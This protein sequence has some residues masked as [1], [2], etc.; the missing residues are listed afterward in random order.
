MFKKQRPRTPKGKATRERALEA[1]LALFR[2]RGFDGTTMRDIARAAGLSLGAAYHYFPSKDALV[3]AYYE[4]IQ[5][6][7]E[8][9][10]AAACPEGAEVATRLHVLLETKLD[11]LARDRKILAALFRNVGDPAH[12][13]SVFSRQTSAIR[14]RSIAQFEEAFAGVALPGD[15]RRL[16]G[17]VTWLLHLGLVLF[18][19]HDRSRGQSRTRRLAAVMVE[20]IT[21]ILP[22][23]G[24]P[25]AEAAREKLLTIL[26]EL[27]LAGRGKP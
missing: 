11:L 9:R 22:Y 13:L 16:A 14:R 5:S 8:R 2:K 1:A 10:A 7:H 27:G 24:L 25:F 3:M 26:A 6:E 4:R 15:W 23:L 21:G 18:F 20:S 12:P 19:I 17:L